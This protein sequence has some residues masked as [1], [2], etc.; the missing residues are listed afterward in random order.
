MVCVNLTHDLSNSGYLFCSHRIFTYS[1]HK[2]SQTLYL[3]FETISTILLG[4]LF[5][6]WSGQFVLSII[7]GPLFFHQYIEEYGVGVL[8]QSFQKLLGMGMGINRVGKKREMYMHRPLFS[9]VCFCVHA[10]T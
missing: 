6:I 7:P 8:I 4:C 9:H 10:D 1:I 2:G 3:C 5:N